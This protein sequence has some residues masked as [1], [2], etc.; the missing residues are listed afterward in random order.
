[1]FIYL[2]IFKD[3]NSTEVRAYTFKKE[4]GIIAFFDRKGDLLDSFLEGEVDQF[5]IKDKV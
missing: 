1:M 5:I 4:G 2:L 3:G